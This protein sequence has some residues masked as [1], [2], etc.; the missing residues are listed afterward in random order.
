MLYIRSKV[1]IKKFQQLLLS[2]EL[3]RIFGWYL[4]FIQQIFTPKKIY[5]KKFQWKIGLIKKLLRKYLVHKKIFQWKIIFAINFPD[6]KIEKKK[7]E[8][9][10]PYKKKFLT[11]K[12]CNFF[13][14]TEKR[15]KHSK[16]NLH[17][18]NTHEKCFESKKC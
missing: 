1:G 7:T 10:I 2:F 4:K 12:S 16:K 6:R 15:W 13:F 8:Q 14:D 3:E 5:K 17:Q 18:K 9:K 11:K